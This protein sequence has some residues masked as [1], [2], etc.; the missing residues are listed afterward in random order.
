MIPP[1]PVTEGARLLFHNGVKALSLAEIAGIHIDTALLDRNLQKL[2][3]FCKDQLALIRDDPDVKGWIKAKKGG[4][5]SP[6]SEANIS[7]LLDY[8]GI[9]VERKKTSSGKSSTDKEAL[10]S[11]V[12]VLPVAKAI[13]EYRRKKKALDS[14][15]DIKRETVDGFLH[16]FFNLNSVQ[17]YRGSSDSI[18]FQNQSARDKEMAELIR[19]CFIPR[20]GNVLI[21]T[22]FKGAEVSIAA[23]YHKDPAMIRELLTG[24][25]AHRTEASKIFFLD[26][27]DVAKTVRYCAKNMFVFPQFYGA[28]WSLC[29]PTLWAAMT[30]MKLTTPDGTPMREHLKQNGIFKLKSSRYAKDGSPLDTDCFE[31]HI[32]KL[33]RIMWDQHYPDY[34]AWKEEWWRAYCK[35]GGF[36]MLTGFHC[37]GHYWKNEVIN[38]PP[39]G[40]AFHC[41]L[42]SFIE[43][44]KWLGRTRRAG[45][46]LVGQI[47]D[48]IIADIKEEH[49][50]D[51][52][53]QVQQTMTKDLPAFWT[54][55][56]A[57]IP[58]EIDEAPTN[59]FQK[60]S[61]NLSGVA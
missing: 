18:N 17:S 3:T 44:T 21:E 34:A 54:W 20:K 8:K 48:S 52:I 32:W 59:W 35:T 53:Q 38:F 41:L 51:Y 56:V 28:K 11:L 24:Y 4:S 61:V 1:T 9:S 22:D 33:E 27:A 58:V 2:E 37:E 42:W 47:H 30:S 6:V 13:L 16:P 57:P 46:H 26:E 15:R 7:S 5:F 49:K 40:T 23:C 60:T 19:S 39:Q 29:A 25:D 12:D 43:I 10:K 36:D 55:I 31:R 14:L 45:S 50:E